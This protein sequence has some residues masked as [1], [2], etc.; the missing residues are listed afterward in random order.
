M[1]ARRKQ[2]PCQNVYPI[3]KSS[4]CHIYSRREMMDFK[5]MVETPAGNAFPVKLLFLKFYIP[6]RRRLDMPNQIKH[7]V[8]LNIGS[9]LKKIWRRKIQLHQ[10]PFIRTRLRFHMSQ[11]CSLS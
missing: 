8:F 2:P 6:P 1:G 3:A 5:K 9:V 4:E 7:I 11:S 10:V